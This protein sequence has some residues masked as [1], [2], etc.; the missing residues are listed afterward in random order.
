MLELRPN[1]ECCDKDLPPES[2]EAMICTFECTFCRDC[3]E[4][5]LDGVCPNCGGNFGHR[6]IRP[7]R[8]L[9]KYPA[10]TRRVLKPE[11]C[12]AR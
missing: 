12:Q 8:L 3:V 5:R 4:Q 1:C 6:P 10:S 11:G 7:A 9:A 2:S